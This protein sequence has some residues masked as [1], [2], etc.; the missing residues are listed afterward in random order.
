MQHFKQLRLSPEL[1]SEGIRHDIS[2]RQTEMSVCAGLTVHYWIDHADRH[3]KIL[4]L[5]AAGGTGIH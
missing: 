5:Q 4:E 2:G 3:I 1:L